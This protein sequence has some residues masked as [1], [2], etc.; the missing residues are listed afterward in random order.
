MNKE[1]AQ[2]VEELVETLLTE[3]NWDKLDYYTSNQPSLGKME[4][5]ATALLKNVR[6]DNQ[7]VF[8]RVRTNVAS[9]LRNAI[10]KEHRMNILDD[11]SIYVTPSDR[12]LAIR[13]GSGIRAERETIDQL[14]QRHRSEMKS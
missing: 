12:R 6:G 13:A 4:K 14:Q 8:Q 9:A 10:D 3:I 5:K 2:L 11:E 7:L 1:Y